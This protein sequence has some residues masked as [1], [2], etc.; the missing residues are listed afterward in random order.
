[1]N[2]QDK[3]HLRDLTAMFALNGLLKEAVNGDWND[4]AIA[5]LAYSLADAMMEAR[6]PKETTGLPPIK[7]RK[8]KTK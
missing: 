1:M 5:E 8:A 2:E 3:Q 7:S 4:Q 6:E